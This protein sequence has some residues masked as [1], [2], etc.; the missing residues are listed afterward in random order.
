MIQQR[1]IHKLRN[2]VHAT[3]GIPLHSLS[4]LRTWGSTSVGRA[5][6]MWAECKVQALRRCASR[7]VVALFRLLIGHAHL[8]DVGMLCRLE[9]LSLSV[10]QAQHVGVFIG[11]GTACEGVAQRGLEAKHMVG[12]RLRLKMLAPKLLYLQG[13]T[14]SAGLNVL[15]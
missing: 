1:V 4:Q 15:Q 13:Q 6:E 2:H 5:Q 10:R 9:Q 11:L 12:G 14:P 8:H 3:P 7:A